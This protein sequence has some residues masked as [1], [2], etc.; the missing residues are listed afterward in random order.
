[1]ERPSDKTGPARC[2]LPALCCLLVAASACS[3]GPR[4]NEPGIARKMDLRLR[5]ALDGQ[6]E[7][8]GD[9]IRVTVRLTSD[10]LPEDRSMLASYGHVGAVLGPIATLTIR[11][12]RVV[13]L[14][15]EKRV[16]FIELESFNVPNPEPPPSEENRR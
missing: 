5:L 6:T 8:P 15:G 2:L 14:A 3:R 1:M 10:P 11:P 12:E 13:P 16:L 4:V 7:D 9:W